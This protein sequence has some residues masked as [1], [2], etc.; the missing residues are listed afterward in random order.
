MR[1][2]LT[3]PIAVKQVTKSGAFTGYGSVFGVV[4]A[5]NEVV[6]EGAYYGMMSFDQAILRL[7]T[8]GIVTFQDALAHAT[9]PTDFKLQAQTTGLMTA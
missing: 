9:S 2:H 1:K 8:D 5:Y 6:A 3:S 7:Y 4:D